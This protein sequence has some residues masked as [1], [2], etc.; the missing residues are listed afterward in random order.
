[1]KKLLLFLFLIVYGSSI[2][3]TFQRVEVRGNIKVPSGSDAEGINIFNKNAN[4]GSVSS[5]NG[6]FTI[7]V[8]AGDSLYFSA[9]QF[10]DLLVVVDEKVVESGTL[11][12]EIVEG[13]NEL[14]EVIIRPHN[15]SG[16]LEADLENI[17]VV[18][19][20]LSAAGPMIINDYDWEFRPDAQSAVTNSAMGKS[21]SGVP[22]LGFNV[23][24][25]AEKL[26]RFLV[27]KKSDKREQVAQ[28][29]LGQIAVERQIRER[30]DNAFFEEVLKIPSEEIADFLTFA[31]SNGFYD[32]LL[33]PKREMDLIEFLVKKSQE[34]K[35]VQARE[36]G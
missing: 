15:L 22:E 18:A 28:R 14:A 23:I 9:V 35:Q 19:I 29:N 7:S 26:I 12:V 32:E 16:N 2:A 5:E 13:V 20:D 8:R 36:E 24:L 25:L 21:G 4:R 31:W 11:N 27:P 30:F 3:Q 10:Q 6:N 17:E 34:F 1:M 33:E